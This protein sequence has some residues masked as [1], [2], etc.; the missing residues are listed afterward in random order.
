MIKIKKSSTDGTGMAIRGGTSNMSRIS[1]SSNASGPT[2]EATEQGQSY[3]AYVQYEVQ[4]HRSSCRGRGA[5][6]GCGGGVRATSC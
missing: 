6:P 3:V 5:G 2:G 1:G 4:L